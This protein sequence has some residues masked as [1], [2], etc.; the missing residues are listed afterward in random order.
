MLRLLIGFALGCIIARNAEP[1]SSPFW[2]TV[3]CFAALGM[4]IFYKFGKRDVNLAVA[5]AVSVA[6]AKAESEANAKAQ[7]VANAAVHIFQMSGNMP[8]PVEVAAYVDHSREVECTS[9]RTSLT[10]SSEESSTKSSSQFPSQ[11]SPSS[12]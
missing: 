9:E 4:F 1:M 10:S 7:A 8:T 2:G 3:I 12:V 6:V 11:Y 5:T